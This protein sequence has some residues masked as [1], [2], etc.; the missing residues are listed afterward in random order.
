MRGD[1]QWQYTERPEQATHAAEVERLVPERAWMP[2][3]PELLTEIDAGE[4][5]KHFWLAAPGLEEAFVG[6]YRWNQGRNPH[7]FDVDGGGRW[8][9][10]EITHVKPYTRPALPD[11]A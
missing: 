8:T 9:S 2:L 7:G 3:T 1:L 4:H 6:A 10:I 11:A 5:G